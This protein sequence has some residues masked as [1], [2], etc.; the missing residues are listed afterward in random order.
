MVQK[1]KA[2]IL[3][4][5]I[6]TAPNLGYVWGKWEQDV[7][8]FKN[9][10]YILSFSA[11]WLGESKVTTK[12]LCDY[13]GYKKGSEDDSLLVK[14]LWNL[15]D[16]ADIIVA[17]NGDQ[18]DIKKVN[19]RFLQHGMKPPSIYKTIDTKKIAKRYFNFDSN[20][21]DDLGQ[22]LSVG[23]KMKHS[24]FEIWK[25][26]MSGDKKSW[27]EMLSYNKQD[28]ILLEN[29]YLKLRSWITNHPNLNLF[30]NTT[31]NCP[32]CGS[33]KL[34]RR[35]YARNKVTIT[36]RYQCQGCGG[37]SSGAMERTDVEIK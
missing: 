19:T 18:F 6:E 8:E 30:N 20:K 16:K 27:R 25:G 36:Q 29:V 10:W 12:G 24:G 22:Y 21:L 5:D 32:T 9:N 7:I 23:R 13:K 17:H 15:F 1:N 31:H 34:Q 2:R 14:D 3:L 37:W 11:K 28:V 26:C 33:N 4:F 35:G